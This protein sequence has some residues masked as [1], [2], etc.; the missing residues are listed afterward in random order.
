VF[1]LWE[2]DNVIQKTRGKW[3]RQSDYGTS[4]Q[5]VHQDS[6][7]LLVTLRSLYILGRSDASSCTRWNWCL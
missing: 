5:S 3:Q 7:Q 1:R 4:N 6:Q 2:E